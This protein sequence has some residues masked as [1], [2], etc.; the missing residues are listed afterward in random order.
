MADDSSIHIRCLL[1][2]PDNLRAY[3]PA[4]CGFCRHYVPF[5][6]DDDLLESVI[7]GCERPGGPVFD[8]FSHVQFETTCDGFER[9]LAGGK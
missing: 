4:V 3:F 6:G 8:R 7:W 1:S 2:P 9:D 5:I